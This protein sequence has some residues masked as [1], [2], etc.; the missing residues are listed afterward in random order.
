MPQCPKH[1][2]ELV[3]LACQGEA[4]SARKAKTSAA[5]GRLG[6]RPK[7]KAAAKRERFLRAHSELWGL[8]LSQIRDALAKAGLCSRT[9]YPADMRLGLMITALQA[10]E[11]PPAR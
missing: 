11:K 7:E 4:T 5:N 1:K 6:G 2:I 9:S 8:P 3:C 10:E